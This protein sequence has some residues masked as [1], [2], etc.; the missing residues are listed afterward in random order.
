MAKSYKYEYRSSEKSRLVALFLCVGG[1]LLGLHYFYVNR[2]WRAALNLV[3]VMI[4]FIMTNIFGLRYIRISFG[5]ETGVFM[6]WRDGVAVCA[7]AVLGLLWIWDIVRLA[8]RKFR[9]S[10]KLPLKQ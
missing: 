10:E 1:G 3:L 7:A 9:D 4:V 6:Y 8:Q 5:N 2:Y